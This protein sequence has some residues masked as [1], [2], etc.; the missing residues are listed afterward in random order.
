MLRFHPHRQMSNTTVGA[1][2]THLVLRRAKYHWQALDITRN[3]HAKIKIKASCTVDD[4]SFRIGKVYNSERKLK[5][6]D[7]TTTPYCS[8]G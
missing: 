5:R 6:N 1:G 8:M 4:R 2:F 7:M 3:H